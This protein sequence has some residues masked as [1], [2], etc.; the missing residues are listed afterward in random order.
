MSSEPRVSQFLA[1]FKGGGTRANRYKVNLTFPSVIEAGGAAKKLSFTCKAAS[2]PASIMG[3]AEA[4]YMGR[5]IKFAGD[6]E[7][8]NWTITV[9]NDTDFIVRDAFTKWV[10]RILGHESNIAIS[11]WESPTNYMASG[12][13]L[14][15]GREDQILKTYKVEGMFPVRVSEIELGYEQNNAIQEFTVEMALNWWS[16]AGVTT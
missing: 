13:V 8:E 16:L 11:G 3:V 2:I 9:L 4:P 1:N 10:D 7:F 12:E 5:N 15:Y 14:Q 6:V